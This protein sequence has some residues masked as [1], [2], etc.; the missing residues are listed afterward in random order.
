[1][2]NRSID[3]YDGTAYKILGLCAL[4]FVIIIVIYL[5]NE[6][7]EYPFLSREDSV[8]DQI[9]NIRVSRNSAYVTLESE[10]KFHIHRSLNLNYKDHSSLAELISVGDRII[11]NRFSDTLIIEHSGNN[12]LFLNNKTLGINENN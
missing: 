12:Y 5:Q 9:T 3:W 7:T 1:M 2:I 8:N 4:V 10:R 11:K 6:S